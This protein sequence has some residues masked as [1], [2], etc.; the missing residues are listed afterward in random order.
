MSKFDKDYLLFFSELEI[1]NN[2]EWFAQN[3]ERFKSVVE[4][5]FV[6]FIDAIL[7]EI[8]KLDKKLK[9]EAKD[10]VFRIYRDV[11][12]SKDKTPYKI[13]MSALLAAGGRKDFKNPSLYIELGA[14]QLKVY[15]GLYEPDKVH[16]EK[17]RNKILKHTAEF[18]KLRK[19][20]AFVK[21]FHEILGDKAKRLDPKFSAISEIEPLIFNKA[22][23]FSSEQDAEIILK[24]KAEKWVLDCYKNAKAMNDFLT[25]H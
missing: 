21:Q 6:Q 23:Y 22:F 20:K 19:S 15:S 18:T 13:R 24:G 8:K 12:F 9:I 2:R 10:C 7:K 11:R 14:D 3:K 17:I 5:P 16:L 4:E 25:V 1:N